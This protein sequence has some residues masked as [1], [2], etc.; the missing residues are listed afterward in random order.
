MEV[1]NTVEFAF[2]KVAPGE[3]GIQIDDRFCQER[4]E[5]Y[6]KLFPDLDC[7]GWYSSS[8]ESNSDEPTQADAI[9]HKKMQ[10]FTEN[11]LYLILNTESK[12]AKDKKKI[13]CFL[14][15]H[16]SA[17]SPSEFIRLEY[18]LATSDSE[19]IS[20]EHVA[21]AVDPNAKSSVLSQNLQSSLNAIKL[22]RRRVKFLIDLV[23]NSEDVRRNQDFMRKL[24]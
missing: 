11:P 4:L 5:A 8:T 9:A 16:S 15:E 6:K 13:P 14:Y 19:R 24:N 12:E 17:T 1:V 20:V 23:R 18:S 22:L 2:K 10:K 21:K 3:G 7:L